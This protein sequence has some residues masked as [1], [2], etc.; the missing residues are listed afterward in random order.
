MQLLS[1]VLGWAALA[2]CGR[3]RL[4]SG[5]QSYLLKGLWTDQARGTFSVA[6]SSCL[7]PGQREAEEL[8]PWD[9]CLF[10]HKWEG[11]EHFVDDQ[12]FRLLA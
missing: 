7:G 5:G 8:Q 9:M 6:G 11:N 10:Y 3:C 4:P 1:S 12:L 2:G